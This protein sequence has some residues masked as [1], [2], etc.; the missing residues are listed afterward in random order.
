[1]KNSVMKNL[2]SPSENTIL[3]AE[4]FQCMDMRG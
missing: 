2:S 3:I 1:M 4:F